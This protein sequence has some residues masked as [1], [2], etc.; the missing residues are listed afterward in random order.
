MLRS[1]EVLQNK[2]KHLLAN[3]QK[4]S[5]GWLQAA[6]PIIAEIMAK[7][8]FDVLMVDM[9]HGPGDIMALIHQLQA[10]SGYEVTPFVRAPWNDLVMMKRILDAGAH[11]VLIP[12][13]NTAEEAEKAVMA[14]K[15]PPEGMR[16]IAPSPR[17]G[18]FGMDGGNYLEHA[19][20]EISVLV[21]VETREAL[22]NLEA[23]VKVDGVDGIFIGPMDLST[24]MGYFC[25]PQA[26][27]VQEAIQKVEK[28]VLESVKFLATVAGNFEQ[29][30]G[31]Y[32]K[33]Y[34]MVVMMSDTTTLEKAAQATV[35]EF[36]KHYSQS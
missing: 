6:S 35:G 12:Y 2:A 30:K 5:A 1:S 3:K 20:A 16:G 23:I 14:C 28:C 19:N 18:G 11:G 22:E 15:Y 29:A 25:N 31:L 13:V 17:A 26:P 32:E 27:E 36:R 7:A 9:E 34:S 33:G 10:I 8:G 4:V 21:A 24:S